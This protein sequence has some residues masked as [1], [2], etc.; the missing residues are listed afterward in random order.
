MDFLAGFGKA[1]IIVG[2][3]ALGGI[4][5]FFL[6]GYPLLK[7]FGEYTGR[8]FW[9][10]D[11]HFRIVP[12]Y[13]I[14]EARAKEGKY[15]EAVDEYRQVIAKHPDDI[16][17]H[18]RIAELALNHLND[19][20]LAE[21]ELTSAFSKAT[22]QDSTALAAN[23]LADLYQHTLHDPVRALKVMQQLR[24]RIPNTKQAKLAEERIAI[25]GG[26]ASDAASTPKVPDKVS[27]RP[28]RYKMPE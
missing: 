18:V 21:R 14:A 10:G 4:A 15:R 17:P 19:V 3:V 7:R 24:N 1:T 13:S 20:K 23:R 9:P 6:V 2:L 27:L 26:I 11:S 12:E 25:L 8:L 28:S 5:F 22:G 16:Y